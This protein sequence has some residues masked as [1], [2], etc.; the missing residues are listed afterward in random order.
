[1]ASTNEMIGAIAQTLLNDMSQSADLR[2]ELAE[3]LGYDKGYAAGLEAGYA[4]AGQE[5]NNII[6]AV[7]RMANPKKWI[8]E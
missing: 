8:R 2:V 5:L 7:N 6:T 1:M 3:S 4:A